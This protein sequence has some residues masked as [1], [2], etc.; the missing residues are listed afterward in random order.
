MLT[1]SNKLRPQHCFE[2]FPAVAT[3]LAGRL[4]RTGITLPQNI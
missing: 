1:A 3:A 2:C 4:A